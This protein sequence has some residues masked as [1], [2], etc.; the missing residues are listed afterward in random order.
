M[1]LLDVTNKKFHPAQIVGSSHSPRIHTNFASNLKCNK[2]QVPG[3][4]DVK[5]L[6][7]WIH[8]EASRCRDTSR[9]HGPIYHRA[10]KKKSGKSPNAR[11]DVQL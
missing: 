6:Q 3:H 10:V 5:E 8:K 1:G 4:N 7:F 9:I 11:L 2:P